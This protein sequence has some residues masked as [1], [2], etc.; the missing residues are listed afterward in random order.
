MATFARRRLVRLRFCPPV[1]GSRHNCAARR[2][3]SRRS[4]PPAAWPSNVTAISST[5]TW[6]ADP[7][8]LGLRA[9][10]L[11]I[12]LCSV[13]A[14]RGQPSPNPAARASS[15]GAGRFRGLGACLLDRRCRRLRLPRSC[16]LAWGKFLH[17][18]LRRAA[19]PG[20]GRSLFPWRGL[21]RSR[22]RYPMGGL[23]TAIR[24]LND[25]LLCDCFRG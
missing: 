4:S 6:I 2:C 20:C 15:S 22:T 21:H 19:L 5:F 23:C 8:S 16:N 1:S 7:A 10:A 14:S 18:F 3:A 12:S 25:Y 17:R 11:A 9:K 13:L 24:R